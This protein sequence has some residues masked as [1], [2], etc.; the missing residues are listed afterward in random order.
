MTKEQYITVKDICEKYKV[1]RRTVYRWNKSG[2]KHSRLQI[3]CVYD[4]NDV[5]AFINEQ[6]Q[7]YNERIEPIIDKNPTKKY[8]ALPKD[9]QSELKTKFE[10][11]IEEASKSHSE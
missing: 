4:P 7:K 11:M 2:L 9:V 5:E 1:S 8:H 3:E 6:K 10:M